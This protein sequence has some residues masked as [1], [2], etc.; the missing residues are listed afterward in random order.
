MG[1][2]H[3]GN[4]WSGRTSEGKVVVVENLRNAGRQV[5]GTAA[6][7]LS[8]TT[9]TFPTLQPYLNLMQ[10]QEANI[11][12][13]G[14][15]GYYVAEGENRGSVVIGNRALRNIDKKS[16]YLVSST[17]KG[18]V[19]HEIGHALSYRN[20]TGFRTAERTLTTALAKYNRQNNTKLNMQQF[21]ATIS[22]YAQLSPHE[23]FAEA[24]TDFTLNG[25]DASTASIAIIESWKIDGR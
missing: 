20:Q 13:S 11:K 21:T 24:F 18:V 8:Q 6:N 4:S 25:K 23:A 16:G 2:T 17:L 1:D 15:L 10:F 19:T 22:E 12:T 3:S 9:K 5:M 14:I 7:I